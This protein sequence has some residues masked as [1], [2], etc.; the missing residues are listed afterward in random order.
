MAQKMPGCIHCR[1]APQQD[2]LGPR[3]FPTLQLTGPV[4]QASQGL[5]LLWGVFPTSPLLCSL[6]SSY[7]APAM[8]GPG[9]AED[10]GIELEP[11]ADCKG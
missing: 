5:Q 6:V 9:G 1:P 4:H 7:W 2:C 10:V 11:Q 3:P 8:S